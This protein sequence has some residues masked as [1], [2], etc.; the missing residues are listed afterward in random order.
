MQ[1]SLS[2]TDLHLREIKN[3][4][5]SSISQRRQFWQAGRYERLA[6]FLVDTHEADPQ[7]TQM[8]QSYLS[9]RTQN[10]PETEIISIPG[11]VVCGQGAV[12]T[13]H[14]ELL[15]ESVAEF[16]AHERVPDGL[17]IRNGAYLLRSVIQR[18]IDRPCL[19]AK[20]PWYRNFGHWLVDAASILALAGDICREGGL[21]VV[22]GQCE[23]RGMRRVMFETIERVLPKVEVLIQPDNEAWRFSDLRYVTPV[24]VPPLFKLPAGLSRLR[25]ALLPENTN[26]PQKK[27]FISRS[28]SGMARG[29][30]N[31]DDIIGMCVRQGY[32]LTFPEQ[33]SIHEQAALFASAREIIGVKGAA[34]TN[35]LFCASGTT[36]MVLSPSDF[37]DP[38]FWDI[39]GQ[40]GIHYGEVF[41]PVSERGMQGANSFTIDKERVRSMLRAAEMLAATP[42][43]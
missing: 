12:I 7:T 5:S 10:Y 11:A 33:L 37:P 17:G 13:R 41:G 36:V 26:K 43:I 18:H 9:V 14:G 24:H 19:L 39:C 42:S 20:R 22:I 25:D 34:L 40:R 6:P 2:E 23:S 28:G 27:L 29:L 1:N 21:A 4:E 15:R 31:E 38:F 8:V 16:V 32:E 30:L 35:A 3:L